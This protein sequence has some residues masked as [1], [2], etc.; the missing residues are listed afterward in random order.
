MP[1][2]GFAS[3]G[4]KVTIDT[5]ELNFVTGVGDIG[6]AP[7]TLDST[8]LKDKMKHSVLG[9][10][11]VGNFEIDFLFDNSDAQSDFRVLKSMEDGEVHTVSIELPDGPDG[12]V[13]TKFTS[14]G[15][16]S[17]WTTAISVNNLIGAK[18]AIALSQDWAVT[19][20]A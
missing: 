13:G 20:P 19:N 16:V 6:G 17:V 2:Q 11:D 15:M 1:K 14:A 3:I 5:A 12:T 8:S 9:V 4:V 18:C 10:Q 7:A